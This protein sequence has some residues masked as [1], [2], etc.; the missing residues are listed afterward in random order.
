MPEYQ[1]KTDWLK[2]QIAKKTGVYKHNFAEEKVQRG[3][4]KHLQKNP[5]SRFARK[6]VNEISDDITAYRRSQY[7]ERGTPSSAA[8]VPVK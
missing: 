4:V 5:N 3:Q 6:M 2:G 8:R 1:P 7:K